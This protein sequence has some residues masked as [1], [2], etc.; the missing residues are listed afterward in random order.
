MDW[1]LVG[2]IL[3][4]FVLLGVSRLTVYIRLVALQGAML[5][6]LLILAKGALHDW[7]IFLMGMAT[8]VIKSIVMPLLLARSLR[9]TTIRQ[10]VEPMVSLHLSLLAGAGIVIF[11]FSSI[12]SLPPAHPPFT[13]IFIPAALIMVLIG[14]FLLISRS[15]AITQVIGFL[16]LENGIFLFGLNLVADFPPI[17]EMGV[18]LDILVG[19][20]VMG[21]MIYHINRT[22]DHIHINALAK[23]KEPE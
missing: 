19:V 5:S 22:F 17:V 3:T 4:T 1:L 20:F 13:P 18:L 2:M 10:E 15:K 6:V 23:L 21:I 14:F 8:L 9:E 16:V 12:P 7:H 11:A